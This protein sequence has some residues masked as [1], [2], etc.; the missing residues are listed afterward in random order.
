[1]TVV[2]PPTSSLML[3]T[4]N[5]RPQSLLSLVAQLVSFSTAVW[6][7]QPK[8]TFPSNETSPLETEKEVW[9][10]SRAQDRWVIAETE[11]ECVRF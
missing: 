9:T 5:E 3:D 4:F 1:M 2:S 7:T 8:V 11:A 6:N 10:A